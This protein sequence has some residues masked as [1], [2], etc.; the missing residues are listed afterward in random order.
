MITKEILIGKLALLTND[1]M[2]FLTGKNYKD[3][4]SCSVLHDIAIVKEN[5]IKGKDRIITLKK[6]VNIQ[7]RIISILKEKNVPISITDD[8]ATVNQRELAAYYYNRNIKKDQDI[9]S[10]LQSILGIDN[11]FSLNY[12]NRE[13]QFNNLTEVRVRNAISYFIY[14]LPPKDYPYMNNYLDFIKSGR[15]GDCDINIFGNLIK[16]DAM[17]KAI[18]EYFADYYGSDKVRN[19]MDPTNQPSASDYIA[20]I[21]RKLGENNIAKFLRFN[22]ILRNESGVHELTSL[23][24]EKKYIDIINETLYTYI[25]VVYAFLEKLGKIDDDPTGGVCLFS[26]YY[27]RVSDESVSPKVFEKEGDRT[28]IIEPKTA[29][30][31]HRLYE[32]SRSKDYVIDFGNGILPKE[33]EGKYL[34]EPLPLCILKNEVATFYRN[35]DEVSTRD[36]ESYMFL[37]ELEGIHIQEIKQTELLEDTKGILEIVADNTGGM[38]DKLEDIADNTKGINDN[39]ETI[40]ARDSESGKKIDDISKIQDE[41]II[42]QK[43]GNNLLKIILG[44]VGVL[45]V[46]MLVFLIWG[47]TSEKTVPNNLSPDQLVSSGDSL[48]RL[49]NYEEAGLFYKEALAGYKE[50]AAS[51]P[52]ACIKLAEMYTLGKGAYSLDSALHYARMAKSEPSGCGHGWYIYLLTLNGHLEEA[53]KQ[54]PLAVDTNDVHM[55]LAKSYFILQ[56]NRD[57][58]NKEKLE[59]AFTE[60]QSLELSEAKMSSVY[61]FLWGKV[62]KD[63]TANDINRAR[64][65]IAPDFAKGIKTLADLRKSCPI[66]HMV[67][68]DLA[69]DFGFYDTAMM[70]Y[71]MAL[72]C[73]IDQAAP[74]ILLMENHCNQKTAKKYKKFIQQ[75][76][77][78]ANEQNNILAKTK[79]SISYRGSGSIKYAIETQ[80]Q[81]IKSIENNEEDYFYVKLAPNKKRLATLLMLSGDP[82]NKERA[83]GMVSA[84]ENSTDTLAILSYL[85][86]ICHMLKDDAD[87]KVR[88]S[89]VWFAADRGFL[90][91]IATRF[92]TK[93]PIEKASNP[94][95]YYINY[96]NKFPE[97]AFAKSPEIAYLVADMCI[98]D[99]A[100]IGCLGDSYVDSLY[101]QCLPFTPRE[102]RIQDQIAHYFLRLVHKKNEVPIVKPQLKTIQ[103]LYDQ[104]QIGLRA[105][106]DHN[107]VEMARHFCLYS[108]L[109]LESAFSIHGELLAPI[110]M[111]IPFSNG[112]ID[113]Y[114]NSGRMID[115]FKDYFYQPLEYPISY[116]LYND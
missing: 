51:N 93:H 48:L 80:E 112:R 8:G 70:Y 27:D 28:S 15:H 11:P 13:I 106:L 54:I 81:I 88:D 55:K 71:C 16:T 42:L 84:L 45:F 101:G 59:K 24:S 115:N 65:I 108:Y 7:K 97:A 67:S 4:V 111:F 18:Y 90:P 26:V 39:L 105:S 52:N 87:E 23:I 58:A 2:S 92:K 95:E 91:A 19:K 89:L 46:G 98:R 104:A 78:L 100:F 30:P 85:Q 17:P 77:G 1:I 113:Y 14:L 3:T 109:L 35:K 66:S 34:L 41:Q 86:A 62:V 68:G 63:S 99:E 37:S 6:D 114:L 72:Q 61:E 73:G 33:I 64:F 79:H 47:K 103:D 83:I 43:K 12:Y 56:H 94:N 32:L 20:T 29:V 5:E 76:R 107:Q 21:E 38:S 75:A 116:Y 31:S 74:P 44:L 53:E 96:R 82:A 9:F 102:Y 50:I 49:E 110:K 10:S 69:K 22:K 57:I 40:N 60:L 36:K 25:G